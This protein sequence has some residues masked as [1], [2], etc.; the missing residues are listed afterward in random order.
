MANRRMI[1]S[2]VWGDEKFITFNDITRLVW[3]GLITNV[4][5]QGRMQDNPLLIKAQLFPADRKSASSISKAIDQL[6][7]A[8][9]IIRYE[10]EGKSLVQ[11]VKWWEHQSPSWAAASDFP[12]PDNWI[13][14]VKIHAKGGGIQME[15]W[16]LSGGYVEAELMATQ[17]LCNGYVAPTLPDT[18]LIEKV[19][20]K[21][22]N[23]IKLNTTPLPPLPPQDFQLFAN[24]FES[25]T[26]SEPKVLNAEIEAVQAILEAGG[27]PDDYRKALQGMQD[28]DYTISSMASALNWTL[29]DIEKRK[30]PARVNNGRKPKVPDMGGYEVDRT[31]E[32]V[33]VDN[34]EAYDGDLQF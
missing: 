16:E 21:N 13:D 29:T 1:S 31:S 26:G 20:V 33:I 22:K 18:Q 17:S 6:S 2:S 23:K 28:K 14:R 32:V 8:G 7:E 12:A 34:G 5:D 15:N 19:K 27:T 25:V 24:V 9:M 4:D 3:F 11:I 10:K 30:R